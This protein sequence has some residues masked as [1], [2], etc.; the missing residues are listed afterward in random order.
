MGLAAVRATHVAMPTCAQRTKGFHTGA[1]KLPNLF[2]TKLLEEEGAHI[3]QEALCPEPHPCWRAPARARSRAHACPALAPARVRCSGGAHSPSSPRALPERPAECLT[4]LHARVGRSYTLLVMARGPTKKIEPTKKSSRLLASALLGLIHAPVPAHADPSWEPAPTKK[5]NAGTPTPATQTLVEERLREA[6]LWDQG[7]AFHN[8][9]DKLENKDPVFKAR[10]ERIRMHR[11]PDGSTKA[12]KDGTLHKSTKSRPKAFGKE[13]QEAEFQAATEEDDHPEYVRLML[14]HGYQKVLD[15]V[16]IKNASWQAGDVGR[17]FCHRM[18]LNKKTPELGT[19]DDEGA[20]VKGKC[21]YAV[22]AQRKA[23]T[24]KVHSPAL[25]RSLCFLPHASTLPPYAARSASCRMHPTLS[26]APSLPLHQANI[27][28]GP[29]HGETGIKEANEA[30]A[31]YLGQA[32][33][34][35]TKD[36]GPWTLRMYKDRSAGS[37]ASDVA[38]EYTGSSFRWKDTK[39]LQSG[40]FPGGKVPAGHKYKNHGTP[41]KDSLPW[42]FLDHRK[43]HPNFHNDFQHSGKAVYEL[44][45]CLAG[46]VRQGARDNLRMLLP[47]GQAF[48]IFFGSNSPIGR[49]EDCTSSLEVA[50]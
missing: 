27:G 28:A 44:L 30:M 45:F 43:Q 15:H 38:F 5:R 31:K 22:R 10:R 11:N 26:A 1:I 6:G 35:P 9:L 32:F 8:A 36:L 19:F 34:D 39:G 37:E 12:H 50:E 47:C 4:P 18:I 25:R 29:G 46:Q 3:G 14:E 33:K 2:A 41:R 49:R 16:K 13:S 21:S 20:F 48:E 17:F 40:K 23:K 24:G 42:A 7:V